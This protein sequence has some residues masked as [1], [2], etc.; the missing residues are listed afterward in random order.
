MKHF[1]ILILLLS[2]TTLFALSSCEK[3]DLSEENTDIP[4]N[5]KTYKVNIIT[6]SASSDITYPITVYAYNKNGNIAAQQTIT[7]ANEK[8][9]LQLAP[10]TYTITAISGSADF[11]AGYTTSPLLI[12]HSDV[13]VTD[14]SA[15]VNILLTYAVASIKVTMASIP[16][17]VTAVTLS[18]SDQYTSIS[19]TG[20]LSGSGK[21]NIP[22]TRQSD[23]T[24]T[25]GKVYVLPTCS[26]NTIMSLSLTSP[27]GTQVFGL[28][29]AEPLKA[30]TPYTFSGIYSGAEEGIKVTG[31]ITCGEWNNE[32]TGNFTFGPSSNNSFDTPT[33]EESFTVT[34]IPEQGSEWNGH[35]VAYVDGNDA[36]LISLNE[37]TSLTSAYYEADPDA[38]SRIAS[39]YREGTIDN[40][41]IPTS[42]QARL[43]RSVWKGSAIHPLNT[44][45]TNLGGS[46]IALTEDNDKNALYLCQSAT[47]T[48]SFSESGS[49]R[50]AGAT[51]KTYRLRL[52]K[53]VHFII[54]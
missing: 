17:D 14:A 30:A 20:E 24:W 41:I 9:N 19:Q 8:I 49:I 18:L 33:Q 1:H 47:Y 16:S 13:T 43:L 53:A 32:V 4:S 52:V 22:C 40:W 23:G 3:A 44:V 46:P 27:S 50:A 11:S 2:L 25:T 5:G 15:T 6:R 45:I 10:G 38:A 35:V 39:D 37:W 42:D 36:L 28:T 26:K 54:K 31:T 7:S 21:S 12:G 51:V 29:Y 48:F 34:A